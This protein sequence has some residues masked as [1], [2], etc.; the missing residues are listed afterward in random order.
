MKKIFF[1][2]PLCILLSCQNTPSA[3]STTPVKENT[4]NSNSA[5][6]ADA[7]TTTESSSVANGK[8]KLNPIKV[9]FELE[10][11]IAEKMKNAGEVIEVTLNITTSKELNSKEQKQLSKYFSEKYEGIFAES[12]L[13]ASVGEE[14]VFD[15]VTIDEEIMKV[16]NEED[17]EIQLNI[18]SG[19]KSFENNVLSCGF[20]SV[21]YKRAQNQPII[22]KCTGI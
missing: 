19:R 16:L 12:V 22:V 15:N 18:Y 17:L 2:L 11:A 4:Q 6:T 10:S 9:K 1:A 20:V 3:S 13:Q 5:P 7:K 8:I 14:M 21:S